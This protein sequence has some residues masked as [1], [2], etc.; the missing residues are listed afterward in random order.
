MSK[1]ITLRLSDENYHTFLSYAK[2]ENRKL[3]NTIE[4][5]A[6]RRLEEMFFVDTFEMEEILSN[7][8]L[9]RRMKMGS[10]QAKRMKGKLVE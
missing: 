8:E 4:T 2:A 10:K 6:L 5:L 7:M 1:T 9:L 3:A